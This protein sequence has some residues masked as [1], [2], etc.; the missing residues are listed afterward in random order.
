VQSS[1]GRSDP[2]FTRMGLPVFSE[3]SG[4]TQF[5]FMNNLV[6]TLLDAGELLVNRS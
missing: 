2:A 5:A 6:Y 1:A 3:F 4:R